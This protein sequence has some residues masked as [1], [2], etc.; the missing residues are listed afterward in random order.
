MLGGNHKALRYFQIVD[1]KDYRVL[2]RVEMGKKLAEA[3]FPNMSSAVRP[4]AITPDERFAYLQISFFHGFAE[5]DVRQDKVTRLA[6]LP[7][8][9]KAK[10][11]R[12][13]EYVL[14]SAHH[15]LS[16]NPSGTKLC[17]AGTM[18]DYA[19]IV[20]RSDFAYKV[21]PVGDKPYWS[22]N[23]GDGR[24]CFVSVSGED[25]VSVDLLR[26]RAG[27]RQHPRR[28]PPAAHAPGA[29]PVRVPAR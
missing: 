11:L 3:G 4:M 25:R 19:A 28:R 27:D 22:T 1:A 24:N 14:D 7:L 21:V 8:S 26:R 23:S 2:R 20:D 15:G 6:R 16:I 9:E 5:Y 18:S 12:R 10:G 13:D 17:A 29:D